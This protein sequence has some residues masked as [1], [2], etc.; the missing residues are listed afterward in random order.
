AL[1]P[2]I[3]DRGSAQKLAPP[4]GCKDRLTGDDLPPIRLESL[5]AYGTGK[6][7][8]AFDKVPCK[9][10]WGEPVTGLAQFPQGEDPRDYQICS[11][12]RVAGGWWTKPTWAEPCVSLKDA[13]ERQGVRYGSWEASVTTGGSDADANL[14]I[15][16]LT[17][18]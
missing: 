10:V 13:G 6:R 4:T 16:Y 9:G 12:I 3:Q 7:C 1:L 5:P 2:L 15:A 18:R 8:V 11:Y 17:P 14:I